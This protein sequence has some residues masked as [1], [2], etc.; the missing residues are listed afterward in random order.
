MV[1][2][3]DVA[4]EHADLA[5]VDLASVAAPLA[6]DAYRVRTAFGETAGIESEDA[7]GLAQSIGHL[8]NQHLEQRSMLPWCGT[9]EVLNDLS[10]DIDPRRN[11]LGI[12]AL[13]MGQQSLEIEMHGV[14]VGFGRQSLLIGHDELAQAIHHLMEDVGGNET[15]V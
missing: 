1:V 9:D 2:L 12:L 7:I 13:Q 11:D 3:R 4:H 8:T 5:V 6:L 15:I 14:L 10:L